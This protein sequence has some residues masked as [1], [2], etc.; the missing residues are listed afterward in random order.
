[1]VSEGAFFL[2]NKTIVVRPMEFGAP[3]PDEVLV[4]NMAVGVCGTDVHIFHGEP[5]STDVNP[6][7]V[8]GH[9]Y[10][11]IVEA[12]GESVDTVR[13][14]DHVTI[15]PNI[16]CGRCTACRMGRKQNCPH[17]QGIGVSRDGGFARY[18]MGPQAQCIPLDPSLDFDIGAMTE[19]LACALHGIDRAGIQPGQTVVVIGGGPIGLLMVQLARLSGASCVVLSEP[20]A[21]RREIGLQVGADAAIDPVLEDLRARFTECSGRDGAD[22]VIECVGIP[23]AARQAFEVADRGATILLFSVPKQDATVPLPLF[24]LFSKELTV[25]G[26]FV[27]PDT[28]LRAV[29]LL[30]SG[31]LQIRPLL[32]HTYGLHGVDQAIA[33]QMTDASIK[34]LVHPQED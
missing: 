6:P 19:P 14:G 22:V 16:Y 5:G 29:N 9:E 12:V 2:G 27:N 4:R 23:I 24:D 21:M 26:S 11:G 7:V 31:R 17:M 10:S 13:I 20:N 25:M 15:D 32:T 1:M 3:G 8:L 34:V 30:N 33:M 28:H 18:C